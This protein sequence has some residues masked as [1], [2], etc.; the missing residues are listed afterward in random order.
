MYKRFPQSIFPENNFPTL[1]KNLKILVWR[2]TLT[3]NQF[4]LQHTACLKMLPVDQDQELLHNFLIALSRILRHSMNKTTSIFPLST[5]VQ[6]KASIWLTQRNSALTF[7][8]SIPKQGITN[9]SPSYLLED[10]LFRNRRLTC[11]Y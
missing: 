1:L 7:N 10:L 3:S 8:P 11:T 6:V 5:K 4:W 9:I 2:L